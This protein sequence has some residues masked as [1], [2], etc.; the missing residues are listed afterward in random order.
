VGEG[1]GGVLLR[2]EGRGRGFCLMCGG[3]GRGGVGSGLVEGW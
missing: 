2:L 3:D 1:G